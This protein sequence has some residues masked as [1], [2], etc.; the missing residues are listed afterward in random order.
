MAWI[1]KVNNQYIIAFGVAILLYVNTIHHG[2]VLDDDVVIVRNT[3]V[4]QG[5]KGIPSI[6]SHDSYAGFERV[7]EGESLLTGG[8]YR[9]LSLVFFAMIYSI[10]GASPMAYHVCSILLF[11]ITC[12]V[13]LKCLRTLFA[14]ASQAGSIAFVIAMLFIVHP[15]HTEVV[16]NVKCMDEILALLFGAGSLWAIF[17]SVDTGQ[18]KWMGLAGVLILLACLAKEN[19]ITLV[20]MAPLAIWCFRETKFI[21]TIVQIIPF[22][23]GV[24]I[25]LVI[26]YLVLGDTSSGRVMHDPLNNPFLEWSGQSWVAGSL[27]AKA[28]TIIYML[29][30]YVRLMV[31]PYPLTHDYF[32]FHYSLHS[33]TEPI[34]LISL[35][36]LLGMLVYGVWSLKWRSKAGFGILFFL[37]TI[38]ITSNIFFPVGA[39]AERFLFLPSVGFIL[40]LVVWGF[41]VFGKVKKEITLPVLSLL[42][43]ALSVL[44]FLRNPAWKSNETLF[45]TDIATSSNSA[46]LRNNLGTVILD[47][48]LQEK[49]PGAQKRLLEEALPHLSKAVELHPTYYDAYL[50]YGACAYYARQFGTSVQ[51]YETASLLYPEDGKSKAGLNY[52]LQ[53]LGRDLWAKGD[54][55]PA[56]TALT[57]AWNIQSDNAVATEISGYYKAMGQAE[58][59]KEW[60]SKQGFLPN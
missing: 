56:I 22:I 55:M 6:F 42:I 4:Q 30:H 11:A 43:L 48:A 60:Q 9:P 1:E 13:L 25:F 19:A 20:V 45:R 51:A 27:P 47:K 3:Y 57:E 54:S 52:A 36:L 7:G 53:A 34:V 31:F 58:K 26:R 37:I 35:I 21:K 15:V 44:S 5:F 39:P 41:Q 33:L 12:L 2:F 46:K 50:A 14:N 10:V 59:A 17:K 40:S 29:G 23:A 32:P 49:D 16:A 24:L 8:R 28:A 18:K 38:S